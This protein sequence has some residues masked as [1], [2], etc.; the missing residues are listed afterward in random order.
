MEITLSEIIATPN[1]S[2]K[3]RNINKYVKENFH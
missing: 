1:L 2:W 3:V